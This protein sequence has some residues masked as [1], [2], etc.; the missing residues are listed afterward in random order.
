MNQALQQA[1]TVTFEEMG[2][3]FPLE[4]DADSE[5]NVK[6]CLSVAIDFTGPMSGKFVLRIEREVLPLAAA[7]MLGEEAP[8]EDEMLR[9]IAGEIANVICGNA[10]PAIGGKNAVFDLSAPHI[11]TQTN[12]PEKTSA[13]A[14]LEM[15]EGRADILL[16]LN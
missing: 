2:Y 7:N 11:T 1:A 13:E 9:D 12:S 4:R 5:L 6:D 16:Y 10:L 15:D 14:K 3:M 8:F